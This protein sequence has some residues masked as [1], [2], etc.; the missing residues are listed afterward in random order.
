MGGRS[1]SFAMGRKIYQAC[2]VPAYICVTCGVQHAETES[3]PTRCAICDDERQYVGEQGQRWTTIAE[4]RAKYGNDLR[5]EEPGLTGIRTLPRFAIGQRALL[6]KGPSGNVLWDCLSYVDEETVSA[7]RQLGGISS[8]AIS[9]PHFYGSCVD[10]S[11]AF[12]DAPIYL[13]IKDRG[14]LM[15]PHPNV[16]L[17]DGEQL[18]LNAG[19]T[20]IS[21]PGHFDGSAVLHW[22]Q[23][24]D[25]RGVL[26][27]GDT[28]AVAMDRRFVSFMY[29]YPNYIPLPARTVK[30]MAARMR[31]YRFER[32]YDAWQSVT[33]D[34]AGALERSA[35]RYVGRLEG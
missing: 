17:W 6:V 24:A 2:F 8:I 27:T 4:M 5:Q 34:A 9:H 19:P 7:V 3:P 10:W 25:G 21:L 32:V 35:E 11:K 26:L 14:W 33:S 31:G 16:V 1:C 20:L 15:R 18:H 22:P 12:R 23:G 13:H 28:I 29:S 30:A